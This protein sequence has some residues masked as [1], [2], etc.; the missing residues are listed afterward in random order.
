MCKLIGIRESYSIYKMAIQIL[1]I[2]FHTNNGRDQRLMAGLRW[3][4]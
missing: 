2:F 4:F 3:P 1:E